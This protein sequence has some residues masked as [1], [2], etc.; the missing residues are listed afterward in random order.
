[1]LTAV[2]SI[3]DVDREIVFQ[4]VT[5]KLFIDQLFQ[6]KGAAPTSTFGKKRN[7]LHNRD[8]E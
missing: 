5:Q 2:Y 7:V 8:T 4:K 3:L 6:K 1:M